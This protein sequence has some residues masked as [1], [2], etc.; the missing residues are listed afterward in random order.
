MPRDFLRGTLQR[1]KSGL[2][3]L[4]TSSGRLPVIPKE[5]VDAL[6]DKLKQLVAAR[7]SV[8]IVILALIAKDM[9]RK[10]AP[11]GRMAGW[12]QVDPGGVSLGTTTSPCVY[13]RKSPRRGPSTS[14]R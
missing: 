14:T 13:V 10:Q 12:Q 1:L 6:A 5:V 7:T 4:A 8:N 9:A 11:H 2:T 3:M